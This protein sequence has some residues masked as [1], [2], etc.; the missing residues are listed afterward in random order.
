MSLK[1][2]NWPTLIS[3]A[4]LVLTLLQFLFGDNLVDRIPGPVAETV[5]R[6]AWQVGPAVALLAVIAYLLARMRTIGTAKEHAEIRLGQEQAAA[7]ELQARLERTAA[8][9]AKATSQLQTLRRTVE[10]E[11]QAEHLRRTVPPVPHEAPGAVLDFGLHNELLGR[12]YVVALEQAR[13]EV[14]DAALQ[15]MS[16]TFEPYIKHGSRVFWAFY[17]H[18][19]ALGRRYYYYCHPT[20]AVEELPPSKPAPRARVLSA[21]PWIACPNWLR[22]LRTAHDKIGPL[23]RVEETRCRVSVSEGALSSLPLWTADFE[24]GDTGHSFSFE[25]TS[26]DDLRLVESSTA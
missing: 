5:I 22:I 24:D 8:D 11:R 16:I 14:S 10:E 18:S 23:P 1:R 15:G 9:L 2:A 17:F 7:G 13:Q 20:H 12:T 6:L 26:E 21:L 3:L 25:W 19:P 4:A